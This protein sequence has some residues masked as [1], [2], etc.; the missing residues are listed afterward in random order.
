MRTTVHSGTTRAMRGPITLVSAALLALA[1]SSA[2]VGLV[3]A[4]GAYSEPPAGLPDAGPFVVWGASILRVLTDAAAV[5]TIGFLLSAA[6]LTPS[7]KNGVISREGRKDVVRAS[8][9]AF[10]WAV[11]ALA[12]LFLVLAEVL[13]LPLAQAVDPAVVST[14]ANELPITRAL[15]AM[16]LLA[17]IVGVAGLTTST[18]GAAA[19]WLVVAVLAAVLPALAGHAAGLGDHELAVTA[20]VAHVIAAVLWIGGLIALTTHAL[21]RDIPLRRAVQRFSPIALIAIVLLA[22]SGLAN[23]YTRLDGP[24]QLL[25]TGYGQVTLMKV[26][27]LVGLGVIGYV[28]RARVMPSL[29]S[30]SRLSAFARVA[31]IE[32]TIM[33][34]AIGLGVALATSPYPREELSLPTYGENLLGFAYPPPP[35]IEAVA[36]GGRID[37][38]FLT[39]SLVAAALYVIGYVRVRTRGDSWP[40]MR[41]VCWLGGI[42]IVI[43][44]TNAGISTYAMVSVGLHMVQ[45]MTLT[46]LAPILLVLGA[47]ATLALR[48]LKPSKGNERGPREWL[49]WFLHS[50]IT[51]VLTNP[52]YVFLVYVIGLYGL[53][54]TP[55]F[56]WL[57]GSHVGHVIMQTHFL[58]SGYLFYWVLIGIDPRPKPLPYW[59]RMMLLLLALSVHGFFAVIMMMGSTPMAV[60]WF[61]LVRPDWVTDPLQDTLLGGQ[62]AWGLSEIPTLIVLIVIAVQWA[63]SDERDA[64]RRDRQADRD[65]DAEL[66]AYNAHLAQLSKRSE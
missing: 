66:R 28:M 53:Y 47:P 9:A 64:T 27:L 20:G 5:A 37:P 22:V 10:C 24:A 49:V 59:G 33:A 62:V 58:I 34:M 25:T 16:V 51:R 31:G 60:E 17:V 42:S 40:V 1:V 13:G 14:Y 44:C 21:R 48:A 11:C 19:S 30:A 57:M 12:Q 61:G 45:H 6:F 54:F 23:A 56:G 39:L 35:T 18:S 8:W 2:G 32:L 26:G 36:F 41:L 4:G 55:A 52:F 46:M 63:R 15:L 50:P 38:L 29:D 3:L 43:W 7:G 65:D